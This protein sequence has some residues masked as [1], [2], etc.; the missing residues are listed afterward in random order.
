LVYVA[1]KHTVLAI[2]RATG[3][4]VWRTKLPKVRLRMND[5]VGLALDGDALFASSSG[6]VFCLDAAN[7]TVRWHNELDKLGVG[8]VSLLPAPT[9]VARATDASPPPSVAQILAARRKGS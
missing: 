5:F 8:V 2:D 7:G 1:V 4:E 9:S 3:A 6:E